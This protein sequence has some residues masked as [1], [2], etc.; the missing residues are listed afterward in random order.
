[1][2]RQGV[3][4][5]QPSLLRQVEHGAVD[6]IDGAAARDLR[7][8]LDVGDE[9]LDGGQIGGNRAAQPG[10]QVRREQTRMLRAGRVDDQIGVARSRCARRGIEAER[11]GTVGQRDS[12]SSAACRAPALPGRRAPSAGPIRK[13]SLDAVL[14]LRVDDLLLAAEQPAVVVDARPGRRSCRR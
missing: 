1:M 13:I 6:E 12:S 7:V 14:P 4:M 9:Q 10:R 11:R 3:G 2:I 8:G 5:R